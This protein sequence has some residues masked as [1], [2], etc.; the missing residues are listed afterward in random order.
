MIAAFAAIGS[1]IS[2]LTFIGLNINKKKFCVI[3][4]KSNT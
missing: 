4:E 3:D 1:T 2:A